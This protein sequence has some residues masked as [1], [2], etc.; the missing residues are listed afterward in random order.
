MTYCTL[1]HR[2]NNLDSCWVI[3]SQ[4]Y[5]FQKES[6]MSVVIVLKDILTLTGTI[7]LVCPWFWSCNEP[8]YE[9]LPFSA[10]HFT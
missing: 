10:H 7:T 6:N 3:F 4:F 5:K 9:Y 2:P 8:K 1:H